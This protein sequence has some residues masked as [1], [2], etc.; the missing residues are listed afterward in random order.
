[1]G[2][3]YTELFFLDEATAFAA[4]H[5]P[6]FECR[7]GDALRFAELWNAVRGLPRRARAAE[8]DAVLHVQRAASA[9][10]GAQSRLESLSRLPDGAMVVWQHEACL[11]WRGRLHRW[12]CE[13]Y[14]SAGRPDDRSPL[15][16][17]TP[18]AIVAVLTAG[19]RPL[20]HP[21]AAS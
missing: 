21:S 13:A 18:A 2:D 6:C 15:R 10:Q 3:S 9:G 11:V 5:R 20:V 4:G 7:R 16:V 14:Q 8:M 1:M 19:Y 17:L 12:T